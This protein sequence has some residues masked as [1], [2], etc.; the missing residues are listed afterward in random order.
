MEGE[1]A[2]LATNHGLKPQRPSAPLRTQVARHVWANSGGLHFGGGTCPLATITSVATGVKNDNALRTQAC[3]NHKPSIEILYCTLHTKQRLQQQQRMG[4]TT[5]T[6][7][8]HACSLENLLL[9][10]C[11][12]QC[13]P[14]KHEIASPPLQL[15]SSFPPLRHKT[16]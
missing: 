12:S 13:L 16:A 8:T 1:S 3:T 2:R 6:T 5:T 4:T 9:R 15:I 14:S 7:T 11:A 10:Q